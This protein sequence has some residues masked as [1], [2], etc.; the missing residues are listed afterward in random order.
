MITHHTLFQVLIC[1][2]GWSSNHFSVHSPSENWIFWHRPNDHWKTI[3]YRYNPLSIWKSVKLPR[4]WFQRFLIFA[5]TWGNDP[6]WLIFFRWL[7]TTTVDLFKVFVGH[8]VPSCETMEKRLTCLYIATRDQDTLNMCETY[9]EIGSFWHKN[10][11][12]SKRHFSGNILFLSINR[13]Y[14]PSTVVLRWFVWWVP[15]SLAFLQVF[16][17]QLFM[18]LEF[19]GG[20]F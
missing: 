12:A 14:L 6:I 19:D 15:I 5:P 3:L 10:P 13:S 4:W 17:G 8:L 1:S 7:E 9:E 2:S 18:Y 16:L 11:S 20:S